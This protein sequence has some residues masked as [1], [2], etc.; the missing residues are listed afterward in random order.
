MTAQSK[1]GRSSRAPREYAH[2]CRRA[3]V[4]GEQWFSEMRTSN[5]AHRMWP[6]SVVTWH[7]LRMGSGGEETK[8]VDVHPVLVLL[9]TACQRATMYWTRYV[10]VGNSPFILEA[11]HR[12]HARMREKAHR[13]SGCTCTFSPYLPDMPTAPSAAVNVNQQMSA[14]LFWRP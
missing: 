13:L 8:G 9:Y 14:L 4:W 7:F 5:G 1:V 2:V 11:Y 10:H 12:K 3:C 6:G